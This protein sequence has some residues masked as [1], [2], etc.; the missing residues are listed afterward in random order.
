MKILINIKSKFIIMLNNKNKD[1]LGKFFFVLGIIFLFYLLISPLNHLICQIDEY[2][3]RT[4]LLLPV[5][6]II[7]VTGTDVHPPLYYLMGKVVVELSTF[8]GID[9]LHGLKLLSIVPYILILII[10]STKIRKEY[11]WFT[12]GLFAFALAVMCEFSRY[13]LIGRM[14]SWAVLFILLAF[15]YF[16]DIIY[17][18]SNKKSWVLLTL[19]SLLGAYTHYFAAISAF[20]IYLILLFYIIKFKKEELKNWIISVVVAVALYLPWAHY[21]M[22][23]LAHVQKGYWITPVTL[24]KVIVFFGYYAYNSEVLTGIVAILFLIAFV[25]IYAKE[26]KNIDKKDHFFILSGFGIYLGTIVLGITI[27][28][29]FRPIIDDR[30]LM[31]GAALLWLVTSIIL[32]KI[33]NKKLFLISLVLISILLISGVANTINTY[34]AD[35]HNGLIRNE[36]FDNITQDNNSML[37]ISTNNDSLYFLSYHNQLD[38][39]CL[40]STSVF[41]VDMDRLHQF[42]D[43]K[44]VNGRDIDELIANNSDKN[45][46]LISWKEP[47]IHSQYELLHKDVFMYYVKINTTSLN[48]TNRT[49]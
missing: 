37:I 44:N 28:F 8:L 23:Q 43:F 21:L 9:M 10:S 3:T 25:I 14:Y 42:F 46:Y 35:Y 20:C 49:S 26:L 4:V 45:V 13:Y 12:A 18:E 33:E 11:G 6:D 27:S 41:G 36:I 31:P 29:L 32:S 15:L 48:S 16:R 2:F 34:D 22:I 5:N 7:T 24:E 38:L 47:K 40:N 30:Y 19:F 1:F 39:Y 17:D